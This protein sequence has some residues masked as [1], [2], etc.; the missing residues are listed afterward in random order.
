MSYKILHDKNSSYKIL[1]DKKSSYKILHDKNSSYKIL[2]DKNSS[3]KILH[4]K[5]SSHKIL[6]EKNFLFFKFLKYGIFFIL[7]TI[8]SCS[9]AVAEKLQHATLKCQSNKDKKSYNVL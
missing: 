2:H 5:N 1:N 7:K 8:Q 6:H 3:Y 9:Q 4:D